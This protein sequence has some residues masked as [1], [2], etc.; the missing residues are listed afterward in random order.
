MSYGRTDAALLCAICFACLAGCGEPARKPELTVLGI[1]GL[2]PDLLATEAELRMKVLNPYPEPMRLEGLSVRI[3]TGSNSFAKGAA[4]VDTE[5]PAFGSSE[6]RIPI[7][8]SSLNIVRT[9]R[10]SA[11]AKL[12]DHDMTADV[13]YR[14][15]GSR[16][17]ARVRE[18]GELSFE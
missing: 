10:Q 8:I 13:T 17:T 11:G 6:I 9:V 12:L 16:H 4:P 15:G 7:T 18:S 3:T 1:S 2:K 14:S 5:I